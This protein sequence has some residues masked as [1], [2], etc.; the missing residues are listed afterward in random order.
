MKKIKRNELQYLEIENFKKY[1]LSNN[2]AFEMAIRND[3]I[4]EDFI[5][6]NILWYD[7]SNYGNFFNFS[8]CELDNSMVLQSQLETKIQEE[9]YLLPLDVFQLLTLYNFSK[10]YNPTVYKKGKEKRTN[11]IKEPLKKELFNLSN[12]NL[13]YNTYLNH[14]LTIS[15]FTN[16]IPRKFKS[17]SMD[18]YFVE[19]I[20]FENTKIEINDITHSCSIDFLRPKFLLPE[21]TNKSLTIADKINFNLPLEEIIDYFSHIHKIYNKN[22]PKFTPFEIFEN[23]L[24]KSN[25]EIWY[26]KPRG[27]EKFRDLNSFFSRKN[28]VADMFYIYDAK[29]I[30]MHN[31]S[32]IH[33]L[34]YYHEKRINN[35]MTP[36]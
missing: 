1:E 15:S 35:G 31:E 30:G 18:K 9:Y 3:K 14:N 19:D 7:Q 32:I 5:N 20:N 16:S 17:K 29:K 21:N 33:E 26:T 6:F 13:F 23:E 25:R 2:I 22:K 34:A 24:K 28:I 11:L 10:L 4:L 12:R 8:N 27:E 36:I